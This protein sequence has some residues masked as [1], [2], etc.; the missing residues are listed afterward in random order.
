MTAPFPRRAPEPER[1]DPN[2]LGAE[3][4]RPLPGEPDPPRM[5]PTAPL[6]VGTLTALFDGRPNDL[7]FKIKMD[8]PW[9]LELGPYDF[10]ARATARLL[11]LAEVIR[12]I[13]TRSSP[14]LVR[15]PGVTS[16]GESLP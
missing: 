10:D 8:P 13:F 16:E 6:Y 2:A 7:D 1:L 4:A 3:F 14:G 5:D 11:R 12:E 15:A 9:I